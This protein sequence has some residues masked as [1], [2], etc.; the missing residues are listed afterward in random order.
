M[1]KCR[2]CLQEKILCKS[3]IYPEYMYRAAYDEKHSYLEFDADE[4]SFNKRRSK[5]LYEKL[6]C[7]SCEDIFKA[8]EDYG[9]ELLY[10][11]VKQ[12]IR[13]TK[14][15]YIVK[16]YDYVTFKLFVLSLLWRASISRLNAFKYASLG[17]YENNL[18][19]ILYSGLALEVNNYPCILSQTH[20]NGNLSDG[21]F[22]E[23]VPRKAIADGRT[24]YQFIID[25]V[26]VF[27]GV[28]VCSIKSFRAGSSVN[29]ENLWVGYD[30]LFKVDGF[31]DTF[32]RLKKQN[33]FSVYEKGASNK[34]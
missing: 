3:H 5:G 18:R 31:V 25:G 11:D 34:P 8:Y 30:D 17:V 2:L 29:P 15:P 27:I 24:I 32:R 1:S 9:K 13:S 14:S 33:K 21:V 26:F 4:K 7:R 12:K 28:G 16:S 22:M 10:D 19:E 20:I 23:I 6:F